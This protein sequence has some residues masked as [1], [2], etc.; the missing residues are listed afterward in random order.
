[1]WWILV[2]VSCLRCKHYIPF[3]EDRFYDLGRCKLYKPTS[4]HELTDRVRRN[5]SQCG[6]VGKNYSEIEF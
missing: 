6:L 2:Y 1:M 5:E 3:G 4:F